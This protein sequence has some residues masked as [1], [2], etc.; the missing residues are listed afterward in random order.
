[1]KKMANTDFPCNSAQIHLKIC[2]S[3][4]CLKDWEIKKA[5]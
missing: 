1:M 4:N 2:K 3:E 5:A